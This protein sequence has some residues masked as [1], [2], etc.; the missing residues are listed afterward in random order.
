MSLGFL[1]LAFLVGCVV[2]RA[3]H[4]HHSAHVA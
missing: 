3:L 2:W 4:Q 1:C